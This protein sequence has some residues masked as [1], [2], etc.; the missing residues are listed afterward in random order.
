MPP[1]PRS[2]HH[3]VFAVAALGGAIALVVAIT[4][5]RADEPESASRARD[6]APSAETSAR[7][8][9]ALPTHDHTELVRDAL[10]TPPSAPSTRVVRGRVLSPS[11]APAA[12][13]V[14]WTTTPNLDATETLAYDVVRGDGAF[15]LPI[16][17]RE[18][19]LHAVGRECGE[20]ARAITAEDADVDAGELALPAGGVL[21][22]RV[23][24]VLGRG[25]EGLEAVAT[26]QRGLVW[27]ADAHGHPLQ[28]GL[29]TANTD[30]E[31]RFELRGLRHV[32]HELDLGLEHWI[33]RWEPGTVLR[34]TPDGDELVVRQ[35]PDGV[36]RGR[37][38]DATTGSPLR[39]FEVNDRVFDAPDGRYEVPFVAALTMV[40][41]AH[42]YTAEFHT[43]PPGDV[44]H[45]FLLEPL[46]P[47]PKG[48]LVLRA[49]DERGENVSL[50]RVRAAFVR[51]GR[52]VNAEPLDES[53][54]VR[55]EGEV[56]VV[57]LRGVPASL[58]VD[59]PGHALALETL[60]LD[61]DG[62]NR[63]E[64]VLPRGAGAHVTVLDALGLVAR[65]VTLELD[66]AKRKERHFEWRP[67]SARGGPLGR[68][69]SAE[70]FLTMEARGWI[71]GLPAGTYTLLVH[72]SADDVQ[73]FSFD[74]DADAPR[75]YEFRLRAP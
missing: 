61:R 23:L 54:I 30:A 75:S 42:G 34:V 5:T 64:V 18:F 21:R 3:L 40:A 59:A 16:H 57:N 73:A 44:E 6:A 14:V 63:L 53:T 27:E 7:D 19:T 74:V 13:A 11:G 28:V 66:S 48:R 60:K 43:P 17:A 55:G 8:T 4:G 15:A 49:V 2:P 20:T 25:I 46:P 51:S 9:T 72:V 38:L 67:G 10:D 29:R 45:D 22:G 1:A 65:N 62:E 24:D 56:T 47:A 71:R 69:D 52:W 68:T 58:C 35:L 31:G 33:G 70:T 26:A 12:G 37:V 41:A 39:A 36:L 32:E 50:L